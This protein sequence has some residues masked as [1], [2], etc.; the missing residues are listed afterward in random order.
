[1]WKGAT[2]LHISF[3]ISLNQ[4]QTAPC[5]I[6]PSLVPVKLPASQFLFQG[7]YDDGKE[8]IFHLPRNHNVTIRFLAERVAIVIKSL[9]LLKRGARS[10]F[11]W[12]KVHPA[13]CL[14]YNNVRCCGENG[15]GCDNGEKGECDQAEP[16]EHHRRKLPVVLRRR[17]L[18][19]V[20]EHH[21]HPHYHRR[22]HHHHHHQPLIDLGPDLVGDNFDFFEYQTELSV[23]PRWEYWTRWLLR[24]RQRAGQSEKKS[25]LTVFLYWSV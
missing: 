15:K 20:P 16:V 23:D 25:F 8:N 10:K 17:R 19:V 7:N 1:M 11:F 6:F 9:Q 5:Q 4:F 2:K 3:N 18:V 22:Q 14:C 12:E 21:H 24:G 13:D